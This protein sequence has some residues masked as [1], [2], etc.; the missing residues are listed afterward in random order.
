[1]SSLAVVFLIGLTLD[2]AMPE[3]MGSDIYS[4]R[5]FCGWLFHQIQPVLMYLSLA[6][7][8]GSLGAETRAYAC[9]RSLF[10]GLVS[11]VR[12]LSR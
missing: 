2:Y 7:T 10:I 8:V 4:S 1:M 6:D 3:V 11:T 5:D 12:F 9:V